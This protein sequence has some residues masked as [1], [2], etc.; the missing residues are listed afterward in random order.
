MSLAIDVDRIDAILLA[1]GWHYVHDASVA[2]DAF[3]FVWKVDGEIVDSAQ[4]NAESTGI[5][6]NELEVGIVRRFFAPLNAVLAL[7]IA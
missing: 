1:D 4:P 2:F 6:W 5:T 3:E 7:T